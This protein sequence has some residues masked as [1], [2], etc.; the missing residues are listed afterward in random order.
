MVDLL[1]LLL[2][3][4]PLAVALALDRRQ[5]RQARRMMFRQAAAAPLVKSVAPET[6]PKPWQFGETGPS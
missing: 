2:A 1:L 5:R 4:A 3:F 6:P